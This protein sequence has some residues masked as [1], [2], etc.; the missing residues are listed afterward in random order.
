MDREFLLFMVPIAHWLSRM[1][2]LVVKIGCLFAQGTA[3]Q[4]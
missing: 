2:S 3:P 1:E 4:K